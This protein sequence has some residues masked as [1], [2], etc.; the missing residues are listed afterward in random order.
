MH[1]GGHKQGLRWVRKLRTWL[2]RLIR[3]IER[4]I[5]GDTAAEAFFAT[6]LAR[7]RRIFEQQ[8]ERIKTISTLCMHWRWRVSARARRSRQWLRPDRSCGT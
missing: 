4:K 8:K 3:D 5:V 2:G 6:V 1:T 7:S